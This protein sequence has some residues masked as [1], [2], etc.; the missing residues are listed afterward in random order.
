MTS[1]ENQ[2]IEELDSRS[3]SISQQLN[4]AFD[5]PFIQENLHT[6][7]PHHH[8]HH[9]NQ[10]G[11]ASWYLGTHPVNRASVRV[12]S[13]N[14][15]LVD[16]I[17]C[18]GLCNH[19]TFEIESDNKPILQR[20]TTSD[21]SEGALLKFAHSHT[22]VPA[23]RSKF[24]EVGCIPFS[25]AS[26][27]MLTIHKDKIGHRLII[28]GAPERVL[29]KCS[30]HGNHEILT[31]EILS[32]IEEANAEVAEDGERVLAFAERLLPDIP[33]GC[34]FITDEVEGVNFPISEFRF[35]GMLSL[36]DPPID[37]VPPAVSSCHEAGIQVIMVT[38]D[39]PLT[40]RSIADQ[41]NILN[42]MKIKNL[43]HYMIQNIIPINIFK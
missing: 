7:P 23:L 29:E 19:A 24:P 15:E 33:H 41:V 37:E 27:W 10:D 2:F 6:L 8:N 30:Y 31:K 40:A 38:G 1:V 25:S 42:L 11:R 39:H 5:T 9:N 32:D 14:Q 34:E 18:A 12:R 21:P 22:S 35:I 16:L 26:K 17:R 4:E 36:E 13:S 3:T 43:H 28:K 20:K